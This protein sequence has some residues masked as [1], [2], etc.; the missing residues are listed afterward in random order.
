MSP[1][2]YSN[3]KNHFWCTALLAGVVMGALLCSHTVFALS[4]VGIGHK[5]KS[6]NSNGVK[7]ISAYVCSTL[8]CSQ[9]DIHE[10]TVCSTDGHMEYG[11]CRCDSGYEGNGRTCTKCAVGTVCQCASGQ[12]WDG[13]SCVE[14]LSND[15]CSGGQVCSDGSCTD[16]ASGEACQCT[17][18]QKWNGTD[19][20]ECLDNAHCSNN[21]VCQDGACVACEVG[22][23][24][25]CASEQKWDGTSCVECLSND[26]CSSDYLCEGNVCV[27][28][29]AT[30][31][32]TDITCQDGATCVNGMCVCAGTDFYTIGSDNPQCVTLESGCR[33]NSDCG[34]N[35]YCV[36]Q[37]TELNQPI[38]GVCT[39]LDEAI[40]YNGYLVSK[41]IMGWYAAL[42]WCKAHHKNMISMTSMDSLFDEGDFAKYRFCFG[43]AE[44]KCTTFNVPEQLKED[45]YFWS[46]SQNNH[47]FG[48]FANDEFLVDY[49]AYPHAF[50]EFYA[51]CE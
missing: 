11:I 16:C 47:P 42:N 43:K 48:V 36:I 22:D 8:D 26:D 29:T 44:Y 46:K 25:Q 34:E 13:T 39:P 14:C 4:G 9:S 27:P 10:V 6:R 15:E 23:S 49:S 18:G 1:L 2:P 38:K 33:D 41:N 51:L 35:E 12:K 37:Y 45:F 28:F 20:V 19:C 7:A 30:D 21:Q 5:T 50:L 24:C 40:P 32:N 17:D 3:L 31:C